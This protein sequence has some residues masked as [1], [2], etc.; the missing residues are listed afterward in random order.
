[1]SNFVFHNLWGFV[2]SYK[3][4]AVCITKKEWYRRH[5]TWKMLALFYDTSLG[6]GERVCN[7]ENVTNRSVLW[8]R[9]NAPD[10]FYP[11]WPP[12]HSHPQHF[13]GQNRK[14]HC[15]LTLL[16][17]LSFP[18]QVKLADVYDELELRQSLRFEAPGICF[19]IN[20][21]N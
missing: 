18:W 2:I 8:F 14:S 20:W 3:C 13:C 9:S 17:H 16:K 21:L 19:Q 11:P 15:P 6:G 4:F 5:L 1:M 12:P 7:W 10:F